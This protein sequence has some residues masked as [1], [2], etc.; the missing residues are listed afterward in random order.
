MEG[1]ITLIRNGE[2]IHSFNMRSLSKMLNG[3]D[4]AFRTRE[5]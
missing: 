1:T 5:K 2:I 3:S 4:E